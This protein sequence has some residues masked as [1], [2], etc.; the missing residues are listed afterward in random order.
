ME[1]NSGSKIRTDETLREMVH[2]GSEEY[3]FKYY[4][5]DIWEFDFH[6]VDWHWHP[7]VEFVLL[8][9]GNGVFRVGSNQYE[10]NQGEGV[11]INSQVVHQFQSQDH[12]VIP[13]I[14]FSPS[15]LAPEGSRIDHKYIQPILRN[16]A[17]GLWLRR[18]VDWQAKTLEL[19]ETVCTMQEAGCTDEMQTVSILMQLWRQLWANL[20][21]ERAQTS[22]Q[23][24][25]QVMM[26]YI[27]LHYSRRIT[28]KDLADSVSLS[29]S[30]VLHLFNTYLHT[31]PIQYLLH[32]RLK[33]AAG[34]LLSTRSS[35]AAIAME[36]GFENTGYFCKKFKE[37]FHCTPSQ[38]RSKK[39]SD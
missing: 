20:P 36:T 12:A 13:N 8:R 19:L 1:Q 15:M 6:C 7:E 32:Y 24:Q 22:T 16:G 27:H 18:E 5:E 11:F 33:R 3:P 28:L 29:K 35:V 26:Q 2:H 10:L 21:M 14:V 34:L 23:A 17:D 25:L 30:S 4:L 39:T 37:Q 31:S 38:Y 9:K